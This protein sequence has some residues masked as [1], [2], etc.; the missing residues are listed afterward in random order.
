[1]DVIPSFFGMIAT[2]AVMVLGV[3]QLLRLVP[4]LAGWRTGSLLAVG[5]G[6]IIFAWW[7]IFPLIAWLDEGSPYG[8]FYAPYLL[9]PGVHIDWP[10][11]L[12]FGQPVFNG[13]LEYM[14]SFPASIL[15]IVVGPGLVGMVAGGLQWY[16]LG[17]VWDRFQRHHDANDQVADY[18][19]LE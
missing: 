19:S 11:K 16:L 1:M 7:A 6:L 10:A 17:A 4:R 13:L 8:E 9:V 3:A 14:E 15:C 2:G 18:G 12:L 5:H